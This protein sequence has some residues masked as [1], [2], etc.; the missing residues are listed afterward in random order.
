MNVNES[1]AE[2]QQGDEIGWLGVSLTGENL[3]EVNTLD[4]GHGSIWNIG[5]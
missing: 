1:K 4:S 2:V 5:G 3:E